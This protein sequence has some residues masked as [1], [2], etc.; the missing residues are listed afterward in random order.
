MNRTYE[1]LRASHAWRTPDAFNIGVA[2][3]DRQRPT[4]LALIEV[5]DRFREHTLSFETLSGLTWSLGNAL[6]GLGLATGDRVAILLPQRAEVAIAHLATY[7]VGGVAVPLSCLFGPDA[8][9]HR[10]ADTEPRIVITQRDHLDRVLAAGLDR[11]GS[12][13][14]LVDGPSPPHLGFWECIQDASSRP[15]AP[16]TEAEAPALIVYTSGTT[17]A[18]KGAIHAHRSLLGHLPGFDFSHHPFPQAGDRFWTPADWAWIG[19][20]MDALLPSLFHGVPLVAARRERFEPEW[21]LELIKRTRIRN[22]FL[23]P[24]AL[25]MV[26]DQGCA[27]GAGP[28]RSVISGGEPLGATVFSWARGHLDVTINEIYGQTEASCLAG[29]SNSLW[30][31]KPGSMGRPYPGHT[32]EVHSAGGER[33]RPHEI[34]QI[35]VRKPDP[36]MFLGY[37]GDEPATRAKFDPTATWLRTGDLANVDEEGYLWFSSRDDDI[38]NSAGYRIGPSEIERCLTTHPA[39]SLAGVIGVPDQTRGQ[40]VKAYVR[41]TAGQLP[42]EELKR[43]IQEHVKSRLAAYAYPRELEFVNEIPLT[44]TGKI[45]R[46]TLRE[47]NAKQT[48]NP[49]ESPIEGVIND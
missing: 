29:N 38:V 7:K 48:P 13:I 39:V 15:S 40:V 16:L 23:P 41:L 30:A 35:V 44:T 22:A 45:R 36:A 8:L 21:A 1:S 31:V 28:L 3:A 33:L 25:K 34:G 17:G 19:G 9:A 18:A 47:L 10:L 2:C 42:S 12:R 6:K 46:A 26:H 5:D 32:V 14:L 27:L 4:N 49:D 43:S 11:D 20:L 37:F 24:T